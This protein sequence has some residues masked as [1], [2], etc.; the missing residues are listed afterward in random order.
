[1]DQSDT[2]AT[3]FFLAANGKSVFSILATGVSTAN[4]ALCTKDFTRLTIV[5]TDEES[6]SSETAVL[7]KN[8]N[9]NSRID[10]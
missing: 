4:F 7:L 8:F 2:Y 6:Y 10:C 9:Y 1:M 5:A 3:G